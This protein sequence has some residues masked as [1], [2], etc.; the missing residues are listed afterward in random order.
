MI[1]L[2]RLVDALPANFARLRDEANNAGYRMLDTL[3]S[4]WESGVTRFDRPGEALYAAFA[5]DVLAG[6]GGLTRD[7]VTPGALRMR[8]FYVRVAFRR[9][10][11]G[12][13]LAD[14]CCNRLLGA[15]S[16]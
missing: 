4:E 12:R 6:V 5:E 11:I 8:R 7:Q 15:R 2:E 3:A 9:I 1:R 16:Q 13:T 14:T 10:G